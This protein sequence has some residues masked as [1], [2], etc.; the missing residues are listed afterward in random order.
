MTIKQ[1]LPAPGLAG[2]FI[3]YDSDGNAYVMRWNVETAC[4]YG[5]GFDPQRHDPPLPM[6][7]LARGE[8][9]DFIVSHA[10]LP[11][12]VAIPRQND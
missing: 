1:G 9:A 5:V 7:F 10:L 11:G 2:T 6:A 4:W 3:G 12:E 8:R